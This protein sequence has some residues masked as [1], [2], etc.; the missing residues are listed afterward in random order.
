MD[1]ALRLAQSYSEPAP[2]TAAEQGAM[3]QASPAAQR[4][5]ELINL[6]SCGG[7]QQVEHEVK[8]DERQRNL[9]RS[10]NVHFKP[11]DLRTSVR[12]ARG[13]HTKRA[14]DAGHIRKG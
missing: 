7:S 3:A 1:S 11:H 13:G 12:G 14:P 2:G 4:P 8:V 5:L 9:C 6:L 10:I